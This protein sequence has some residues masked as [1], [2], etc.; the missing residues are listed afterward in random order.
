MNG[1]YLEI[2][3]SWDGQE[4]PAGARVQFVCHTGYILTGPDQ[5][6]CQKGGVWV[7]RKEE[8]RCDPLQQL[9][10]ECVCMCMC[11]CVCMYMC[12]CVLVCVS[13]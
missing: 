4:Y 12:M 8:P 5:Y 11:V 1:Y 2:T 6:L 9:V 13:V 3:G 10:G 7:P